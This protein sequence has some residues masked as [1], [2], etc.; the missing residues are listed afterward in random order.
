M[1]ARFAA[2]SLKANVR[3]TLEAARCTRGSMLPNKRTREATTW[4]CV[5]TYMK[6]GSENR[7]AS[8]YQHH[9]FWHIPVLTKW[10]YTEF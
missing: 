6:F 1:I 8:V 5:S 9:R 10:M 3:S 4:V 7:F 2:S